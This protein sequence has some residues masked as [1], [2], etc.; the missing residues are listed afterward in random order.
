MSDSAAELNERHGLAGA[1]VFRT[2][3]GGLLFADIDN[4]QARA[5]VC[6]QGA[7]LTHWQPHT[8]AHP[9]LWLS[10]A[11]RY[12]PG[13][14]IRGGVPVCWPWFGTPADRPGGPAHGFARTLP[15]QVAGSGQ[16]AD[17]ATRLCL[18]LADGPATRPLWP[19]AFALALQITVGQTL[20]LQLVTRN[21]GEQPLRITEALHT[22]F[23]IGDIASVAVQGLAGASFLDA[24]AQAAGAPDARRVQDGALC[25]DAECDRVYDSGGPCW[26]DDPLLRRRL[27]IDATGSASTVVWNPWEGKAQRLG[28]LGDAGWRSLLCV[29]SGNA[30][31]RAVTVA[32]GGEH[33]LEVRYRVASWNRPALRREP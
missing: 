11:A 13:K 30:L 18:Q 2:G 15:W 31:E 22:Y 25:F 19:G 27:H 10:D 24:L 26:I 3:P 21:T 23:R 33:R 6:L 1:L 8:Q 9:V 16:E 28:D 5:C 20:A 7:Q 12:L 4:A 17:G 32:P 29:E 14:A